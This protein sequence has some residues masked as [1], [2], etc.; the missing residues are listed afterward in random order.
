MCTA[1]QAIPSGWSSQNSM[2][3]R[4]SIRVTAEGDADVHETKHRV[5]P[6]G[7]RIHQGSS[8]PVQRANDMSRPCRLERLLRVAAAA[9][10][11]PRPKERQEHRAT[12]QPRLRPAHCQMRSGFI[13]K[14]KRPGSIRFAHRL[15][16][17]RFGLDIRTILLRRSRSSF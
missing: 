15:N 12:G 3:S 5:S 14:T 10:L 9:A 8:R 2:D 16:G 1:S 11:E 17:R 13:N 6:L 4:F 7:V